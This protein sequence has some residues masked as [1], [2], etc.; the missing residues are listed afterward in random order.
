MK[1]IEMRPPRIMLVLLAIAFSV[2]LLFP[3]WDTIT[4]NAP[5]LGMSLGFIGFCVMIGGWL[6]F[7]KH[8]VA[9][10]PTATTEKLITSVLYS[11]SRNPMYLGMI[12]IGVGIMLFFHSY[13]LY[14]VTL[15]IFCLLNFIFIPYEEA[16]LVRVFG[17]EYSRYSERVRRWL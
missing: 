11:F 14:G 3:S 10:C 2:H 7:Q 13:A 5:I 9:I 6:T 12:L 1:I 16:K 8:K 15:I 17:G 4:F